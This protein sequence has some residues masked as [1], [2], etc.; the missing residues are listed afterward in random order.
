MAKEKKFFN[1]N[2]LIRFFSTCLVYILKPKNKLHINIL[3]I[4]FFHFFFY[5][6]LIFLIWII[7]F[8]I[9]YYL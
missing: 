3:T 8:K 2:L 9:S 7:I 4:D 5:I 6:R 1:Q